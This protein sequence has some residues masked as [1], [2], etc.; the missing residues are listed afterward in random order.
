MAAGGFNGQFGLKA[1]STYGTAVV[2]DRFYELLNEEIDFDPT[3]VES[4]GI[5]SGQRHIRSDDWTTG[6][7]RV[8]GGL[9][10]ELA[11][12]NMALLFKH[13]LGTVNTSGAG[14]Y[15]HVI[16]PGDKTGLGLTMQSGR[17][18]SGGTVHPY[19]WAGCKLTGGEL[20]FEVDKIAKLHLD[21]LGKSQT[22]ATG[23]ASASYTASNNV[24]AYSHGAL[25]VAAAAIKAKSGSIKWDIPMADDRIFVGD[26]TINEPLENGRREA[27]FSLDCEF[28]D[29]TAYNRI[30]NGTEAALSLAFTRSSDSITVAGNVRF[31]PPGTPALNGMDLLSL[32]LTGKF[33][34]TAADST[35]MTV[36]VVSSEAT[37]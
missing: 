13:L 6:V 23:L 7:G 10:L 20:T 1:E 2:V 4:E 28:E 26:T 33:V 9:D 35:A 8:S 22:T 36:T 11:T 30:V 17:P 12:K 14:P 31:D 16:T 19:T 27:S 34:A 25:T 3:R 24:L 32:T 18:G 29:L 37:P 21:V 5:R 15:T